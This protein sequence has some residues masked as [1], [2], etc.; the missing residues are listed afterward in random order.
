MHQKVVQETAD[1]LFNL[2][3]P[4]E[5]FHVCSEGHHSDTHLSIPYGKVMMVKEAVSTLETLIAKEN[6]ILD[7]AME[8]YNSNFRK[9]FQR[10]PVL[11]AENG[12]K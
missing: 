4:Q 1:V 3:N 10:H 12:I 6:G 11:E 2:I 7:Q 9:T 8:T 5:V